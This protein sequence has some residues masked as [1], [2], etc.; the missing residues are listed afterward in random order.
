MNTKYILGSLICLSAACSTA[1]LAGVLTEED[2]PSLHTIQEDNEV[3]EDEVILVQSEEQARLQDLELVA[4]SKGW[5]IAEAAADREVADEIGAI[6]AKIAAKRPDIFIGS[7]LSPEPGGIPSLYIKGAVPMEVYD[8]VAA[9][10]TQ[11]NV[12]DR[13]PFS[14]NELEDRKS[15][16]H[17]I[18]MKRGYMNI[19]TSFD[20][21]AG[22]RIHAIVG[23][24]KGLPEQARQIKAGMP[25][26]IRDGLEISVSDENF[27]VDFNAS[28]GMAVQDDGVFECTAG[29]SVVSSTGIFG[30]TTAGHCTGINQI[31]HPFWFW[32]VTHALVH[33]NQH[34]GQWGD[35]EWKTS[36]TN[37]DPRFYA[38][39]NEVRDVLSIEPRAS[40]SVGESICFYG[41][42]SNS[43]DC[44]FD[45]ESISVSCT[46]S[47]V[48][49]N[50]LVRMDGNSAIGGDSGGGWSWNN[51]AYG[52]VKG[53]CGGGAVFSV[54][55]LYDEAIGVTVRIN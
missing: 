53:I 1:V 18:L 24:Q 54:A 52:S 44:S 50:R 49:N 15:Q 29:W 46:V 40:I 37:E 36:N 17:E 34:R 19:A 7:A 16:V 14:F 6:A 51:R 2:Q 47:G 21:Q 39:S 23:R 5:S 8:W 26:S 55:D 4:K 32:T 38:S 22:G 3:H 12:V 41:R 45:V 42:S 33:Q 13:Q 28:G 9:A 25:A 27:A 30:V 11:I 10:K 35:I 48:F 20:F 31:V 43:R